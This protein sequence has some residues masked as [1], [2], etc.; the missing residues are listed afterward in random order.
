MRFTAK[1]PAR[2]PG[3]E[4]LVLKQALARQVTVTV[5][6]T[7]TVTMAV[8]VA[9]IVAGTMVTEKICPT[10]VENNVLLV[11]SYSTN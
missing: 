11:S 4:A 7:V 5:I 6:V 10:P 8:T 2:E 3:G 9:V 1:G